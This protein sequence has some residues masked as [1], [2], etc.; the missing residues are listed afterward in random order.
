MLVA[1]NQ[2]NIVFRCQVK[3]K[4]LDITIKATTTE[5][6]MIFEWELNANAIEDIQAEQ[7]YNK[8]EKTRNKLEKQQDIKDFS[9]R[10][11]KNQIVK[12]YEHIN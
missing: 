1:D 3:R 12:R 4:S 6:Q 11:P 10:I 5:N 2:S 8:V 7:K 9:F